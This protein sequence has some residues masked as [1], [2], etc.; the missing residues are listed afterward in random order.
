VQMR[1]LNAQHKVDQTLANVDVLHRRQ[2]VEAAALRDDGPGCFQV[3]RPGAKRRLLYL[4]ISAHVYQVSQ[5]DR[6]TS[7]RMSV[8]MIPSAKSPYRDS[9]LLSS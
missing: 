9:V 4:A 8:M 2:P 7:T 1:G 3:R 6:L 5:Q